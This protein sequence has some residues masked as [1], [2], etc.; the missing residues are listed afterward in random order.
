[1]YDFLVTFVKYT[2]ILN[3]ILNKNTKKQKC[4]VASSIITATVKLQFHDVGDDNMLHV[5]R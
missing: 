5:L 1:M 3:V 2:L 4:A